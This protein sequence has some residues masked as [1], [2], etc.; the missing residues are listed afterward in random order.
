[1]NRYYYKGLEGK[2]QLN[3]GRK[4]RKSSMHCFLIVMMLWACTLFVGCK[5]EEM[6]TLRTFSAP[7]RGAYE[8]MYAKFGEKDLFE[9]FRELTL[10]LEANGSFTLC[11]VTKKNEVKETQGQYEYEEQREILHFTVR[12]GGMKFRKSCPLQNGSFTISEN[13]AGKTLILK[14]RSKI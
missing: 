6:S 14:F 11:A 4:M 13:F 8:C 10:T 9:E 12:Y 7:Y 2:N 1:M 3:F 5:A